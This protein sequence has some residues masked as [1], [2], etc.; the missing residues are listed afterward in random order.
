MEPSRPGA[1]ARVP[2]GRRDPFP[3][4]PPGATR[5]ARLSGLLSP[6]DDFAADES[7]DGR[8]VLD[9]RLRAGQHVIGEHDEIGALAGLERSELA[10]LA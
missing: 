4:A 7:Q 2:R 5:N 8:D 3:S 6:E 10:F 1:S 9:A